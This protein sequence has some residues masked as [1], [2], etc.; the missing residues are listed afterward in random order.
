MQRRECNHYFRSGPGRRPL[1][2]VEDD[3][4][5]MTTLDLTPDC[6][7]AFDI[8]VCSGPDSVQDRCPLVMSGHCPV[9]VPD[10][11][12]SALGPMNEWRT[13]VA[14]AWQLEGVP[15]VRVDPDDR[16]A[17]PA[18]LGLAVQAL[19]TAADAAPD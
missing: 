16:P 14:C 6:A 1:V 9:G 19:S 8:V 3:S 5:D 4:I 13:S 18:H 17:W 2:L 15:V 10:V 12:V 11:V 7:D